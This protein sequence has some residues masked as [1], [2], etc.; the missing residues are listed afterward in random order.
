MSTATLDTDTSHQ[1]E[2]CDIEHALD[3]LLTAVLWERLRWK[4]RPV[5]VK[6]FDSFTLPEITD[7]RRLLEEPVEIACLQAIT[8]LGQ[9][10]FDR[11]G[12]TDEMRKSLYRIGGGDVDRELILDAWWDGV[13]S[14]AD[15]WAS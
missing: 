3:R 10:L 11:V 2:V 13:G 6:Y 14:D 12:N 8:R 9:L 7:T 4:G 5:T 15:R 1:T